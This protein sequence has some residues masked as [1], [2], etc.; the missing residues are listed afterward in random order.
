MPIVAVSCAKSA[1]T[2]VASVLKKML[3]PAAFRDVLEHCRVLVGLAAQGDHADRCPAGDH[4]AD[5]RLVVARFL[6]I[7]CVREQDQMPLAGGSIS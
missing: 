4:L 3:P 6:G 7:R 5:Q 1:G 2:A